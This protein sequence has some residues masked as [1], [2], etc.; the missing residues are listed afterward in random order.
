MNLE[1]ARE[2]M[3]EQQIR[4]WEVLDPRVL[5]VLQDTPRELFVPPRYKNQAFADLEVPLDHGQNMMAPKVEGRMLQALDVQPSDVCLE[6]G[7]GS[8]YTAACLARLGAKV[9]SVDLFEDFKHAAIARL[10]QLDI[11]NVDLRTGDAVQGWSQQPRYDVIAVTGSIPEYRDVFERSLTI[12]GRLFIV[13]GTPPVMEAMLVTRMR[14][15]DFARIKLFE[16]EL[17][18]LIGAERPQRFVL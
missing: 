12:G 1:Q 14:E 5:T 13:V 10:R 18:P 8:G 2:N 6:I 11:N 15:E 16:T 7:T 3:I 9:H 17:K 4:T